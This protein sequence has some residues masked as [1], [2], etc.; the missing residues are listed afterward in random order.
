MPIDLMSL[1]PIWLFFLG[2]LAAVGV[3]GWAAIAFAAAS[4]RRD[5]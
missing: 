2:S 4:L 5:R 1:F 3:I